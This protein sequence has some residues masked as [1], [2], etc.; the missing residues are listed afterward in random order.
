VRSRDVVDAVVTQLRR[1]PTLFLHPRGSGC[2]ECEEAWAS[3][4]PSPT[5]APPA[6]PP[7]LSSR[8][9]P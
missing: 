9:A 2:E 3:L 8:R 4:R 5:P 1:E 6:P 7:A